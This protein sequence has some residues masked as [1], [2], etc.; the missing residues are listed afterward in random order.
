MFSKLT[1]VVA[2]AAFA[3]P[4]MAMKQ[5]LEPA[6]FQGGHSG[7]HGMSGGGPLP[8]TPITQQSATGSNKEVTFVDPDSTYHNYALSA[9]GE[10]DLRRTKTVP[11]VTQDNQ[12][13]RRE[14]FIK[15]NTPRWMRNEAPQEK[16]GWKWLPS[17]LGGKKEYNTTF[18]YGRAKNP[19][20]RTA[21]LVLG[22]SLGLGAF[23]ATEY[24]L[25][26]LAPLENDTVTEAL[27]M[28]GGEHDLHDVMFQNVK[29]LDGVDSNTVNFDLLH[30][31][32][33]AYIMT[34]AFFVFLSLY[35]IL[36]T[37]G[38]KMLPAAAFSSLIFAAG[39]LVLQDSVLTC[40]LPLRVICGIIIHQFGLELVLPL[41]SSC[42]HLD[43]PC[44]LV[45]CRVN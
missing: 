42:F 12:Q 1:N 23:C 37:S 3:L 31:Y 17:I 25:K 33:Y 28:K 11:F 45:F 16:F 38:V 32:V 9:D 26:N 30:G 34:G 20:W 14:E 29:H 21:E 2:L 6:H 40:T 39:A 27:G 19:F 5:T 35:F 8:K 18:D 7:M 44:M 36:H 22:L 24:G 13:K 15:A 10:S 4:A 41:W 43:F